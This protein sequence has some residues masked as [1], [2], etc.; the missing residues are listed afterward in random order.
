MCTPCLL[1][2]LS[3]EDLVL[4]P[5]PPNAVTKVFCDVCKKEIVNPGP[6]QKRHAG[7]CQKEHDRQYAREWAKRSYDK[8]HGKNE[9]GAAK[10]GVRTAAGCKDSLILELL[11]KIGHVTQSKVDAAREL[12]G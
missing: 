8:K 3:R 7:E 12:I 5:L 6:H 4:K 10:A 1:K 11:V 2:P 9:A